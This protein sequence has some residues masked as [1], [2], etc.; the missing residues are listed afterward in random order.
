MRIEYPGAYYHV[1][2]RDN[3]REDIFFTD[4]D[5]HQLGFSHKF[6]GKAGKESIKLCHS[7]RDQ[8]RTLG[9]KPPRQMQGKI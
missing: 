6:G 4:I 9:S 2:N 1:M 3:R 7:I 5:R 8:H